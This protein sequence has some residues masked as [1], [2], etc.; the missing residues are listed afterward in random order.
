[1]KITCLHGLILISLM[2]CGESIYYLIKCINRHDF[3]DHFL[4]HTI[5]LCSL[6]S[7]IISYFYDPFWSVFLI[8]AGLMEICI[9]AKDEENCGVWFSWSWTHGSFRSYASG[10]ALLLI[11][12]F[13]QLC[14]IALCKNT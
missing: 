7:A 12:V 9:G 10:L 5:C 4:F 11:G 14:K 3:M 13:I 1:M 2:V 8:I 6:I